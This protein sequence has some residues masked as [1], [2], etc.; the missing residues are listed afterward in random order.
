[1]KAFLVTFKPDS[2]GEELRW[3]DHLKSYSRSHEL[4]AGVWVVMSAKR[5]SEIHDSL[6]G[7]R[8]GSEAHALTVFQVDGHGMDW[9]LSVAV[10]EKA[11]K[12]LFENLSFGFP[13]L[14]KK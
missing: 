6:V 10:D 3:I 12:W 2:E 11:K 4:A 7:T 13:A 5:A 8:R 14:R 9:H 1:M